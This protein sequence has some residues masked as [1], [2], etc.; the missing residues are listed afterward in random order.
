MMV[1]NSS[2]FVGDICRVGRDDGSDPSG[3]ALLRPSSC[4]FTEDADSRESRLDKASDPVNEPCRKAAPDG[5]PESLPCRLLNPAR[6]EDLPAEVVVRPSR[7]LTLRGD[8]GES[9]AL[10]MLVRLLRD[11]GR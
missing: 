6:R 2:S 1:I 10:S 7:L 3:P 11:S 8:D 9:S 4:V 5:L